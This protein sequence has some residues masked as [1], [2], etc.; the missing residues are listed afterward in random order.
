[1]FDREGVDAFSNVEIFPATSDILLN[2]HQTEDVV[3]TRPTTRSSMRKNPNNIHSLYYDFLL[4][5]EIEAA[6]TR[7]LE[8]MM[9]ITKK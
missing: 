6:E 5:G 3:E 9:S 1:M 7:V 4:N 8:E 2:L